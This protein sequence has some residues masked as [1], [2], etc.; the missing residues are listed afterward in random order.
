MTSETLAYLLSSAISISGLPPINQNELPIISQLTS[1]QM[2]KKVCENDPDECESELLVG[3]FIPQYN[4]III[5]DSLDVDNDEL[6]ASFLVHELVHALQYKVNPHILDSCES[7]L[8]AE[9]EAYK[10][11]N[12]YLHIHG[13][14]Y[15]AGQILNFIQCSGQENKKP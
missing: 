9:I 2:D 15:Q 10:V 11:Q 3:V 14:L 7:N 6:D 12:R 4:K 13:Q 5:L 1:I 8:A